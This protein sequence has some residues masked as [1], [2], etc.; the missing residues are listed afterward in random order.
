MAARPP[1]ASVD[2]YENL[3]AG[4][5]ERGLVLGRSITLLDDTESTNDDARQAAVEGAE[6]GTVIV[7]ETQRR[8]R[9]RQGRAW[10]AKPGESIAMSIVVHPEG[11]FDN[12]PLA[13]LVAGLAV[14][15]AVERAGVVRA[16]IKW[17][18][19][20]EIE[21]RKVAGI[22]AETVVVGR[23]VGALVVGIGVNVHQRAFEEPISDR[24]TSV[25]LHASEPPARAS[26]VLDV[27]TGLDRDLLLVLSRGFGVIY[28][29]Y[30]SRDVLAGRRVRNDGQVGDALGVDVGGGLRVRLADGRTAVWASGEV[31]RI[32]P[33]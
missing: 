27:L 10:F 29:R 4:V 13:S 21:G 18:N 15:E 20:V 12:L 6:H 22:L 24:A 19:D 28:E 30:R 16:G 7:A 3:A 23:S 8:G 17:P 26:I 5:R 25:A 2:G 33:V 32:V 1:F 9:G 31:E 14:A 11:S